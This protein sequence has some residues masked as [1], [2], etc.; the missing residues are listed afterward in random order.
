METIIITGASRGIGAAAARRFARPGRRLVL[1]A[2]SAAQLEA[3]A[4]EVRAEGGEARVAPVDFAEPS[5]MRRQLEAVLEEEGA[6][7]GVVL[8][9]GVSNGLAFSEATRDST[10]RE[11][12]VNY[13]AP[14]ELMR[15]VVPEMTHRGRGRIVVVGSL[16]SFVPFPGN[17]GYCASKAALFSFIRSVRIE[18]RGTGVHLGVVLPGYTRTSMTTN[19]EA[20]A[21]SMSAAAVA[22]AVAGCYERDLPL[23]V[24][25]A[26]NR[27]AAHLFGAFP[28]TSDRLLTHMARF[29][30]PGMA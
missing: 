11:M 25:G 27:V 28:A 5:M 4:D 3:R 2:R 7:D 14:V 16:T 12:E 30:I 21:P 13:F 23:V 1:M 18:L 9:A 22:D 15:R 10:Q 19:F 26:M 24:P 29:V 17:A 8:N 6:I 20:R